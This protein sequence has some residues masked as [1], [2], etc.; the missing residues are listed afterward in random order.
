MKVAIRLRE[1]AFARSV[2][3]ASDSEYLS[4]YENWVASLRKKS[5][6]Q[7]ILGRGGRDDVWQD[8]DEDWSKSFSVYNNPRKKRKAR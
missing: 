2:R 3:T 4:D 8:K 7:E 5:T 6:A 1:P